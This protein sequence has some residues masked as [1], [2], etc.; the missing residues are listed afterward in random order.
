MRIE[1]TLKKWNED[2][3]FGFI[4]PV[5]GGS[6]VFIHISAF[7]VDGRRPRLGEKLTFEIEIDKDGRKRAKNVLC[8]DRL[9]VRSAH[10]PIPNRRHVKRGL[11]GRIAL[12]VVVFALALYGYGQHSRPIVSQPSDTVQS[13]EPSATPV[14][15]CDG[16]TRC[17]QMT[18]CAEAKFFLR[19]CPDVKMDGNR[20]GIPCEQQWCTGRL[21]E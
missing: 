3:G 11:F 7:P 12:P 21:R 19:N 14:F 17:S 20:D 13:L 10:R 2:R 8:P 5:Q 18:S 16:R 4:A 9:P 15:R 1:G 6:D